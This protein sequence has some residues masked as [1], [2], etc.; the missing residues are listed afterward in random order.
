MVCPVQGRPK[1]VRQMKSKVKSTLIIFLDI[2]GIVHKEFVLASQTVKSAYSYDVTRRLR[3]KVR[4]L[5]SKL[6]RQKNWLSHHHNAPPHTSF[7]TRDFFFTK[8]SITVVPPT[9]P[10]FLCFLD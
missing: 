4:R 1:K 6:W 3:E 10:T 5:R 7:F 9:R 2:K 8:N